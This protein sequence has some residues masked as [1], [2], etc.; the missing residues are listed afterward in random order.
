[1]IRA[2][3]QGADED[4]KVSR[5][6]LSQ[7]VRGMQPSFNLADYGASKLADFLKLNPDIIKATGEKSGQD[8]ICQ[9]SDKA[10]KSD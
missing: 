7:I 8:P 2:T 3:K 9:V 6:Y 4:G 1:M 10:L 5:A